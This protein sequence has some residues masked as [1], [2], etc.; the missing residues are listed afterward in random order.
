[1]AGFSSTAYLQ[2]ASVIGVF[3]WR[4]RWPTVLSRTGPPGRMITQAIGLFAGVPFIFLTG[5]TTTCWAV[6]LAM[7]GFGLL[8][9]PLR[10]QHLGI[11]V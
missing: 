3:T 10:R 8:Q 5:W 11:A 9:G 4:R 7:A 1:M 2:I 6:V